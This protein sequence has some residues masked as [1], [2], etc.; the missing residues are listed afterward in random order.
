MPSADAPPQA[1]PAVDE[2]A[3]GPTA[4]LEAAADAPAEDV[5]ITVLD[6][7]VPVSDEVL[8][9]DGPPAEDDAMSDRELMLAEFERFKELQRNKV[10]DEAENVAKR[11]VEL[12]IRVSGPR[13]EDTAKSLTNL[14]VVQHQM[15][16]YEAAQQNFEAAIEIIEDNT[17]QLSAALVNPL[18]GLGQAQLSGGRPDLASRT[19]E[20][21]VHITH[22][23]EG[24]HNIDQVEILEA[25]AESNLLLGQI[26]EARNA[27]DMIYALNLR[28]Y[29]TDAM[30]IVP[31]LKRRAEWQRRTGYI[32]DER[33]THR[34]IIRIIESVE[35]DDSLAL[36]DPLMKLGESYFYIDTSDSQNFSAGNAAS[37]EMYFKRAVRIAEENPEADWTFQAN[38]HIALGDYYNFRNDIG[39]ARKAYREA[40]DLLSAGEHPERLEARR[41]A[42]ESVTVLNPEP[43]PIYAGNATRADR[44]NQNEQL[45]EGRIVFS[46]NVSDRGRVSNLMVV[47]MAPQE[48]DDM[49]RA[50]QREL[51]TRI[52]RPRFEVVDGDVEAVDTPDQIYTHTFYYLQDELDEKREEEADKS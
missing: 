35:G 32:L 21:A 44:V 28:H 49:E 4:E 3:A 13:S 34:R 52:F 37:G 33:A 11:I 39:R 8:D 45:R 24:P 31:S 6:Q 16:N 29:D 26:D 14:G 36:I 1:A 5:A 38:T 18:K 9:E 17:D 23:N 42:L 40:W 41:T 51:R 12:S 2:S 25:L 30:E 20:R 22:V 43:I 15:G 7:T 48:Y 19:Y 27:Q 50:A 46:Y 10:Y 47:E